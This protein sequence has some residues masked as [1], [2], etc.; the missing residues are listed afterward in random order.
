MLYKTLKVAAGRHSFDIGQE[1]ELND[2]EAAA[3]LAD[4][5]IAPLAPVVQA[6]AKAEPE[7]DTEVLPET[8]KPTKG[9]K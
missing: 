8:S 2:A 9:K 4:G 5:A 1:I 3:L 7:I 6:E